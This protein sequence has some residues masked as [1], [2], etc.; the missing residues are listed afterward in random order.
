MNT[1]GLS[2]LIATV[3]LIAFSVALGAVVM[4]YGEN[5]VE[6]QAAFVNKGTEVA[7]SACDSISL[8]VITVNNQAQ[9]CTKGVTV[10]V[11]FDNGPA[12]ID[13]VQARVLGNA[14]V[15]LVPN[16]LPDPLLPAASLKTTFTY[17]PVGIPLQ[18]KFTPAINTPNGLTFCSDRAV[19]IDTP[20][21]C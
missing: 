17:E 4:S 12:E 5:Y 10:D 11:A 19:T 6:N 7:A 3:L 1:R 21:S 13:A 20:S 14:G 2:P 18:I 15:S 8:H 16:I 9:L